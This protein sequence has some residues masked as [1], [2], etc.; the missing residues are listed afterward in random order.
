MRLATARLDKPAAAASPRVIMVRRETALILALAQPPGTIALTRVL[1]PANHTIATWTSRNATSDTDT[2]KCS[3]RADC[4]PPRSVTV[5]GTA[6]TN[7]GD[8]ASPVQM[9]SGNRTKITRMYVSRCTRLY[10]HASAATG[11]A[12]RR[13]RTTARETARIEP[14]LAASSRFLRKWPLAAPQVTYSA[15]VSTR[16]HAASKCR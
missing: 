7:A 6:D 10:D 13:C 3:V 1:N 11:R 5:D 12:N 15:P 14:S 8:I 9:T 2:R 16:T 4:R